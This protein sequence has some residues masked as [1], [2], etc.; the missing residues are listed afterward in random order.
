MKHFNSLNFGKKNVLD[1]WKIAM[2][3]IMFEHLLYEDTIN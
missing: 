2:Y 3:Y 1:N